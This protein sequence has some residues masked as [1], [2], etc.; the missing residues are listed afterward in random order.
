MWRTADSLVICIR[1][2]LYLN[3]PIITDYFG[4]VKSN[5]EVEITYDVY[6][7]LIIRKGVDADILHNCLLTNRLNELV[8]LKNLYSPSDAYRRFIQHGIDLTPHFMMNL[9]EQDYHIEILSDDYCINCNR[10]GFYSE[11][12][13][14][15][16]KCIYCLKNYCCYCDANEDENICI[17]CVG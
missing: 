4:Q 17:K 10:R 8:N 1:R 2:N 12:N 3:Q 14:M 15:P 7:D 9:M 11:Q 13:A 16:E 6:K 5:E